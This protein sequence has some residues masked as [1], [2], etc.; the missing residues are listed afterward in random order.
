MEHPM[1]LSRRRDRLPTPVFWPGEFHGE[2]M[3]LQRVGH[4]WATFTSLQEEWQWEGSK[5]LASS[6][7]EGQ[8]PGLEGK[9]ERNRSQSCGWEGREERLWSLQR[10]QVGECPRPGRGAWGSPGSLENLGA[11]LQGRLTHQEGQKCSE[12]TRMFYML[13][14]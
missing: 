4:D 6:C 7:L 8:C 5:R 10:G 14:Y 1:G 3:G 9:R 13:W 12:K 11:Q 2:S